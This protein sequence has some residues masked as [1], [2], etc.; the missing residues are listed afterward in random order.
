MGRDCNV[1][2]DKWWQDV[3]RGY[4]GVFTVH[5]QSS[6]SCQEGS[7]INGDREKAKIRDVL[8]S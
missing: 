3:G 7:E 5:Y 1:I 2:S 6:Y 4:A 8:L